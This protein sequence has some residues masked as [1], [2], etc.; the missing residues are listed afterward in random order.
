M[1][2]VISTQVETIMSRRSEV[3]FCGFIMVMAGI[4]ALLIPPEPGGRTSGEEP[5]AALESA[6]HPPGAKTTAHAVIAKSAVA[7]L[8]RNVNR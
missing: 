1:N 5:D 3:W 7:K 2:K 6:H 4:V 8:A